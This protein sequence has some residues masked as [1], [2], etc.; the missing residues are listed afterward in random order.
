MIPSAVTIGN[1]DGVHIG[2][3][4]IFRRVVE[5]A[6]SNGWTPTVLTFDP[7]PAR[8]V[9]PAK[10]PLLLSDLD[11]RRVWM[12]SEGI[13]QVCVLPF[14]ETF[15]QLTPEAFV[16]TILVDTL[17]A[18][19]VL[20]G[21]NFRFGNRQAGD[22]S[23]LRQMGERFGFTVEI[24]D[25]IC[26]RHHPVSSTEV[27]KLIQEGNVSLAARMLSRAYALEGLVVSGRGV[28]S[29]QTVPTLNLAT[30]GEVIPANGVYVT[31]TWDLESARIWQSV[32]NVGYRP[33][34]DD[35]TALSI[36]TFLL[37]PL[38][39]ETPR[40]IRVEFLHRLRPEQ[41]FASAEALKAQILSD[42]G[43]A[44]QFFRLLA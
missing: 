21:D 33:T 44:V 34:F 12:M 28:G 32:T 30:N 36:E 7:H 1:F 42:A 5:I 13:A 11:H 18:R 19:A 14:D 6:R 24:V 39:G 20:V 10:A 23:L 15:S 31:R 17:D 26:Y 8:V 2:H 41:K 38:T 3:Q 29:K 40:R 43:R 35:S 27:R 22:T 9:A 16:R 25:A 4:R 37:E